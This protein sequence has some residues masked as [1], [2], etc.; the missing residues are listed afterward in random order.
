MNNGQLTLARTNILN[1]RHS[2]LYAS[3]RPSAIMGQFCVD[4]R[5]CNPRLAHRSFEVIRCRQSTV[6]VAI[7]QV[8]S[9]KE[10]VFVAANDRR[11]HER[12]GGGHRA[13]QYTDCQVK[14]GDG[15]LRCTTIVPLDLGSVIV[16]NWIGSKCRNY[17]CRQHHCT[18]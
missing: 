7:D 5:Y 11:C 10:F 9:K 17:E 2:A 1:L 3:D 15:L 6:C 4:E 12:N 18:S 13:D 14:T 8:T 16:R